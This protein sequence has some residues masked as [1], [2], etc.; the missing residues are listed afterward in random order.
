MVWN[1]NVSWIK[2]LV[3]NVSKPFFPDTTCWCWKLDLKGKATEKYRRKVHSQDIKL[4]SNKICL[5]P[6]G[7]PRGSK[8]TQNY[9]KCNESASL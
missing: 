1:V 5:K 4:M 9:Q 7:P 6:S 8:Q 2:G 3:V